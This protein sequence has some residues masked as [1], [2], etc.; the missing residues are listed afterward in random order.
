MLPDNLNENIKDEKKD[1]KKKVNNTSNSKS[2]ADANNPLGY[3]AVAQN[4][5]TN[6]V[7]RLMQ[8]ALESMEIDS[9]LD[10]RAEA[11]DDEMAAR[12]RRTR[13]AIFSRTASFV[14][15]FVTVALVLF[16]IPAARNIGISSS[17]L[18]GRG[19]QIAATA[20]FRSS[21]TSPATALSFGLCAA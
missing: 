9:G 3:L 20:C 4:M 19:G 2:L 16:G 17:P 21:R 1:K 14:I 18:V 12:S 8:K 7:A 5:T 11:Y 6:P 13:I 10:A 15:V